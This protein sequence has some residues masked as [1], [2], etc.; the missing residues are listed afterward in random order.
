MT[1]HNPITVTCL[2]DLHLLPVPPSLTPTDILI[3]TSDLVKSGTSSQLVLLLPLHPH[4]RWNH[5]RSLDPH[6]VTSRSNSSES[7]THAEIRNLY[8]SESGV[9]P[10]VSKLAVFTTRN[11]YLNI[12]D[13]PASMCL[14][15]H[16]FQVPAFLRSISLEPSLRRHQHHNNPR[17]TCQ[18][19]WRHFW[20]CRAR[21]L[22]WRLD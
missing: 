12:W 19:S 16:G 8:S 4:Y 9:T 11:R 15:Q 7:S 1:K 5:D 3:L 2:P 6:C 21:K 14:H 13:S 20:L 10:L 22:H 18:L 17:S